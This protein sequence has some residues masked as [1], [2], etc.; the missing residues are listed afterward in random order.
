[1][2]VLQPSDAAR[3]AVA[4]RSDRPATA[5]L[6]DVADARLVVFRI[7][8]GQ[9]VPPHRN[10]SSVFLTV[11]SGSGVLVGENAQGA[12]EECVC[13]A[14]DMI[15]YVPNELHGMRAG[16]EELRILATITPR[17]GKP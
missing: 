15:A 17:P 7:A 11:L 12:Q 10:G 4:A 16:N 1:M 2:K 14:G 13:G 8:P 3:T 9:E 6:H 5:I